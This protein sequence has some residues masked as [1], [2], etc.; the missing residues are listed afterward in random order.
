MSELRRLKINLDKTFK[1]VN[2]TTNDSN[3]EHSSS[4]LIDKTNNNN[5]VSTPTTKV[6]RPSLSSLYDHTVIPSP[7][8]LLFPSSSNYNELQEL[9]KR[10][11]HRKN[12]E[13]PIQKRTSNQKKTSNV[14]YDKDEKDKVEDADGEEEKKELGDDEEEEFVADGCEEDKIA[15]EKEDNDD[16]HDHDI[17]K[18]LIQIEH[19]NRPVPVVVFKNSSER[20]HRRNGVNWANPTSKDIMEYE[21]DMD[22]ISDISDLDN[23][24]I[25]KN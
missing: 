2:R 23:Y 21:N 1:K 24:N 19:P 11:K 20:K 18:E 3:Q 5:N 6:S 13:S 14:N 7:Y 12:T 9:H 8:H 17:F 15:D 22:L 16:D 10:K 25:K 4:L